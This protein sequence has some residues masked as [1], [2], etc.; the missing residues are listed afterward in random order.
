[1][2]LDSFSL[3]YRPI[4]NWSYMLD[5]WLWNRNSFGY[6]VSNV[7]FH[8]AS[9]FLLFLLL[10]QIFRQLLKKEPPD[11]DT[12]PGV[13]AFLVAFIWVIH[14]IHNAAVAYISGRAD[15]L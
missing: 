1:L 3:Y 10:S 7:C 15:S 6:H 11:N 12:R 14:P 8:A 4:Q 13:I 5:Y 2:F 9:G